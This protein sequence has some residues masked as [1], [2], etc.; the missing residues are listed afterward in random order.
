MDIRSTKKLNNGV[1]I[2]YFGLG[3]FRS[4]EGP[5]TANAVKWAIEAGYIHIDTAAI[6]GNEKSTG[7]GVRAGGVPREKLFITTKLWNDDMRGGRQ[8]QAIDE[9]LKRLQLDY[10]D[11]YLIH[12]PVENFVESWK[13]MEKIYKSGKAKAIGVSNFQTHHLD[14]LL[15]EAEIVP[16]LN[17]IELHPY[18]TQ[19]PLRKYCEG[20][21]IAVQA[22]SPIGGQGNDLLANPVLGKIAAKYGKS[23]AQVVIRWD[24]QLGIITIPKSIRKERIIENCSVY[25]FELT[26]DEI[27]A[28]SNL[29]KNERNGADPDNFDF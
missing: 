28:I 7:E 23:P 25:D 22:W 21:G 26:A 4:A 27:A 20:K 10:V 12:W 24:L 9:S 11:L 2:P 14:K 29:N 13:C 15:A 16:A 1:E 17:Q 3:V 5:E 19:E 8:M 6:Y 18:L